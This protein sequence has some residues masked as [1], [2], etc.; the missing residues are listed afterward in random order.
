MKTVGWLHQ[1][2]V[3]TAVSG[4]TLILLT[5]QAGAI[6]EGESGAVVE[7]F[8]NNVTSRNAAGRDVP[9]DITITSLSAT[10]SNDF[11][12]DRPPVDR[13]T[14]AS[15]GDEFCVGATLPPGRGCPF[16]LVITTG[17]A[18][19]MNDMDFGTADVTATAIARFID[20][21][22]GLE[23]FTFLRITEIA[24]I[25]DPVPEPSTITML[26][27]GILVLVGIRF[28]KRASCTSA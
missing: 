15:I 19:G 20:Q 5:A 28:A 10:F 8:V 14:G 13:M 6:P 12:I 21:T 7:R 24:V 16:E 23:D 9:V 26:A 25:D 4:M 3:A 11:N 1:I 17:D 22:T 2:G 18:S 27:M